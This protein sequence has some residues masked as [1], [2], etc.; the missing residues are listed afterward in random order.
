MPI[1][2]DVDNVYGTV[3]GCSNDILN[4]LQQETKYHPD[5]YEYIYTYKSGKWHGFNYVF[6]VKTGMF[7]RGLLPRIRK[8]LAAN[9]QD[10]NVYFSMKPIS[11]VDH[12]LNTHLIRPYVFQQDVVNIVEDN[13]VGIL[14]A[15]TG[16]GKTVCVALMLNALKR[17]SMILVT[18]VVLLDQ[19]QQNLQRL[20]D[21]PIGMVGDGEFDLQDI[22]V[23][24]LQSMLSI[25]KAKAVSSAEKRVALLKH[26]KMVNLV[27]SD[28]AHLYDSDSTA[29]VM[30]YF[31]HAD[32]IFGMSATPYGW[33]D[34]SE[35]RSN[36]ELEQHFGT[37]VYDCRKQDFI[38]LG[39]KTTLM[40]NII[41][42]NPV[43]R[44]YDQHKKAGPR[45]R[46]IPD[47]TKN[48]REALVGE[49]LENTDHHQHVASLAWDIAS[50][51]RSVFVHAPHKLELSNSIHSMIPGSVL[52]NGKTPRLE[53]RRIYDGMRKR[54]I[55]ALVSDVGGTG[56]DIPNLNAL[57]LGGDVVDIRQL[58]GRVARASPGKQHGLII[59][60]AYDTSFLGKH[61]ETRRSQYEH[62]GNVIIG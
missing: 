41:N 62:D 23:S 11:N 12:K 30:P 35:K 59:D 34:K 39:L 45:G 21:Q 28:E 31:T 57:I 4:L 60:T 54:E 52:V 24:T 55:L 27:V 17:R 7:R 20:F 14:V 61:A 6:D 5:G 37:V 16:S 2:I 40:V 15:P 38:S 9:N 42:R 44:M 26:L 48:Y 53:R 51:G 50:S 43:R 13:D 46:L 33:A 22:T 10:H 47:H 58:A 36:I 25:T 19:M 8:I 18:D 56:L 32:K 29:E 49:I 3:S 1:T